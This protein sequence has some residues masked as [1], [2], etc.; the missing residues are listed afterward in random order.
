MSKSSPSRKPT[1]RQP[2]SPGQKTL[3]GEESAAAEVMP[4]DEAAARDVLIAE[5]V[6]NRPLTTVFDY[7]V[8][9]ELRPVIQ[10]GQRVRVPF[11]RGNRLTVGYCVGLKNTRGTR[12]PLK[13]VRAVVDAEPMLSGKMLELTR[14]MADRYLCGW[15]Q[16]LESVIPAAVKRRAG[17]RWVTVFRPADG[18]AQRL[19]ELKLP[20]KQRAVL[21]RLCQS[22]EPLDAGAICASV[23]CGEAPIRGLRH[24]GLVVA[25][26]QRAERFRLESD[27][28][29]Q[30]QENLV[31]NADQQRA[32]DRIL[33]CVRSGRHQTFLLHGVTG[34]GKTEV[35][36]QAIQE[37]VSYGR[38]AIVL[39]PEISLT[40]QTIR[41]FRRR[42]DSVAVLHSHL[43]DVE[44]HWHWQQIAH[45]RVQVVVGARSAV[46]AP[47]PHLGLIVIDE[48][49][50][51]T[52]KQETVPRYHAREV[53]RRRAEMVSVPLVLGSATPTLESWWR[54]QQGKDVLLSLPRRVE[55]R[56]LPP[57]T[58]VD[59]RNDP[60]CRR[61]AAIGRALHAAMRQALGEAKAV[62]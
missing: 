1:A 45:G 11:G 34:S 50:E 16:V 27:E 29:V 30:R 20:P 22:P 26:R 59:I 42:F 13:P 33:Q 41:R 55:R 38:Q 12:K 21:E 31:L 61:G 23:G 54:A 62:R 46:F 48:E 49:H 56:P 25:E 19:P 14:W 28:P 3:F 36:I 44:R 40:P 35:Y 4:W 51:T 2:A 9:D 24:K 15:G 52:F 53:A 37:I 6:F 58:L 57:I 8:P 43:S 60:H 47:V 32:L 18:V 17:T 5:V 10:P 7:Y 39:V